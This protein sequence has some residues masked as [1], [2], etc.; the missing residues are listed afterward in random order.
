MFLGMIHAPNKEHFEN[1][2]ITS[3]IKLKKGVP[4]DNV[5]QME[6]RHLSRQQI[7]THIHQGYINHQLPITS[8]VATNN[9]WLGNNET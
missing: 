7:E 6:T 5:F 9:Q 1:G 8:C 3:L 2:G 4:I